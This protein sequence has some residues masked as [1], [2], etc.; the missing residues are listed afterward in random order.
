MFEM[1][2][3][4]KGHLTNVSFWHFKIKNLPVLNIILEAGAV[5]A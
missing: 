2:L 4:V 5:G 3:S 1:V